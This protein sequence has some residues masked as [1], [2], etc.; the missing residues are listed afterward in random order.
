MSFNGDEIAAKGWRTGAVFQREMLPSI[1]PHLVNPSGQLSS[2]S[3]GADDWLIIVSQTCDVVAKKIESEPFVEILHCKPIPKLRQQFKEL[4]ST[5]TLDFKPNRDLDDTIILSAH[6]IA[7]RYLISRELLCEYVPDNV[8]RLSSVSVTR[9]LAWYS[10]R[11]ARPAWPNSFV[12]RINQ[13]SKLLEG[14]LI[15]LKD[16]IAKVRIS[17]AEKNDE[18][19][20][21]NNYHVAIFFIVDECTW[22]EDIDGRGLAF[23]AYAKFTSLLNSCEGVEVN[24]EMSG[25]F[26]G[27]EF[28][29]QLTRLSD[30]WNFA[31]LTYRE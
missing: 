31:N 18:L 7:D 12:M 9:V 28:S 5:R 17:I 3:I 21:G 10:L 14:A 20:D 8:R 11:Y 1:A 19:E 6:A 2:S 23:N 16:D 30:E 15:D 26:S 13:V 22:E 27:A 4:R 29:W 25:V 24:E